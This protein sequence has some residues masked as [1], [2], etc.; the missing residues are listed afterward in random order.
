MYRVEWE[1]CRVSLISAL[2][3]EE[4]GPITNINGWHSNCSGDGNCR[5][6]LL[7]ST[8]ETETDTNG[9]AE[10]VLTSFHSIQIHSRNWSRLTELKLI[11]RND[12]QPLCDALKIRILFF[13]FSFSFI[14]RVCLAC[15][16]FPLFIHI[17]SSENNALLPS[18]SPSSKT[19]F[20]LF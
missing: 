14:I 5:N 13:P 20:F 10:E 17:L 7:L 8:L 18:S 16:M 6:K 12:N 4:S 2:D 9:I 11:K 15:S 3:F 19:T 1:H